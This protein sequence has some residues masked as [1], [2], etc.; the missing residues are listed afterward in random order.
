V[1]A[2]LVTGGAAHGILLGTAAAIS[3]RDPG[4]LHCEWAPQAQPFEVLRPASQRDLYDRQVVTC[5]VRIVEVSSLD[6]AESCR[7]ER[8]V[9]MMSYNLHEPEGE[10]RHGDWLE[11]ARRHS[12]P[13]LLDAAADTPP[14]ENLWKFNHLGYDMV[15]ISGGKA[16]RGPQGT[17]LLLGRRQWIDLAKQN[18]P[19]NEG[20]IGRVAKASKEDIVALWKAI[21]WYLENGDALHDQCWQRIDV[22]LS[23]LGP[24]DTLSIETI[25]PDVANHFPHLLIQWDER[26]LGIAVAELRQQLRSGRPRI[27]TGRVHGTGEEGLLVSVIN[28]QP[29]E[30]QIVGERIQQLLGGVPWSRK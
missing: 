20:V 16:I 23:I 11:F 22:L 17:G 26:Q 30:E 6:E 21:E 5:G 3:L 8:T 18:A 24:V 7:N 12:L 2:A 10:I 25:V 9:M 19:P 27:A 4:F 13:T 29:G 14:I 15:V 28:L 1:E